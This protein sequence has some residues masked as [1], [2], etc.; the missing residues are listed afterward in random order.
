GDEERGRGDEQAEQDR[1]AGHGRGDGGT[2]R[3]ILPAGHAGG[4]VVE[5]HHAEHGGHADGGGQQVVGLLE[6]EGAEPVGALEEDA[7]PHEQDHDGDG[8]DTE[9]LGEPQVEAQSGAPG[10]GAPGGGVADGGIAGGGD[11]DGGG[12]RERLTVTLHLPEGHGGHED[13]QQGRAEGEQ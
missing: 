6:I 5:R 12:G 9:R 1:L 7:Q 11:E 2:P 8:G 3:R 13:R 4:A 10:G